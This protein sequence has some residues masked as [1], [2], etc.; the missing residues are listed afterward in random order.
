MNEEKNY[1]GKR[2]GEEILLR[3][4]SKREFALR[5]GVTPQALQD[6][7]NGKTIPG[8]SM[9]EKFKKAGLDTNYILYGEKEEKTSEELASGDYYLREIEHLRGEIEK[10]K[11]ELVKREGQIELLKSMLREAERAKG[12]DVVVLKGAGEPKLKEKS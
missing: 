3:Y 10:L 12:G 5:I 8:R 4:K 1:I 6:Y 9:L 7:L 2:L 11:H